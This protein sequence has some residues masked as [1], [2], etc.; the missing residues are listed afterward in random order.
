ME[1]EKVEEETWKQR[2][3]EL[4]LEVARME[5]KREFEKK[6]GEDKR[7]SVC[8]S[9]SLRSFSSNYKDCISLLSFSLKLSGS[10]ISLISLRGNLG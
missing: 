5:I 7:K 8:V 10:A 4:E 2:F 6:L 9:R 3:E 1:E